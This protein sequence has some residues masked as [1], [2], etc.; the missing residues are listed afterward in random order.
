ML[1]LAFARL[2]HR[3]STQYP[4]CTNTFPTSR[5]RRT[6]V[7]LSFGFLIGGL[8]N[9]THPPGFSTRVISSM[10]FPLSGMCSPLSQAQTRSKESSSKVMSRA[11]VTWN[12]A[13]GTPCSF[14]SWVARSTCID[15]SLQPSS[16]RER[17]GGMSGVSAGAEAGNGGGGGE[18]GSYRRVFHITPH[19]SQA[20]AY[21]ASPTYAKRVGVFLRT[22]DTLPQSI[23]PREQKNSTTLEQKL[24]RLAPLRRATTYVHLLH[25]G[26]R[27]RGR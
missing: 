1:S 5:T 20:G 13:F 14:A 4:F 15:T 9:K 19:T 25:S 17:Y 27:R 7:E 10:Y 2:R 22:K 11:F 23:Y 21:N 26:E 16:E 24:L 6:H 3:P 8:T 12:F 18:T